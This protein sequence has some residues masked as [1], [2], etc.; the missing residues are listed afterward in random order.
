MSSSNPP[1]QSQPPAIRTFQMDDSSVGNLS[2]SVNLFRGDVNLTQSLFTLPGRSQDNGLDVTLSLLYQS[3]VFREATTW[4]REAPTGV[5]GLGWSLPLTWIEAVSSDSPVPGTRQYALYENGVPNTLVRQPWAPRLFSADAALAGGPADGKP[6]P[7][8]LV[9]EFHAHGL[10][11]SAD[12]TARGGHGTWE[13]VD[14]THELLYTLEVGER[15]LARDGGEAYQL[16]N[17]QFWKIQYYPRYE[18]WVVTNDSAVRR[19]FGGGVTRDAAG[20]RSVNETV[21]WS[22]WWKGR[23]GEPLWSGASMRTEEQVQVAR[24]WYLGR[25]TDRFGSSVT[26]AYNGFERTDGLLRGCEQRVGAGGLPYTK[27]VYLTRITDVFGR[28]VTLDYGDKLWSA[29]ETA[30]REYADPHRAVPSDAPG[31]WQDR[32]ET[33]FLDE[34]T[35]R[36]ADGSTLFT[37]RFSYDPRP[38]ASGR[39]REVANVT[40][41]T[42][43]LRGDT[44]KRFLTGITQFDQDGVASPGLVLG[45]YLDAA[46]EGGQ[47][48]ALATLT[49]PEGGTATYTYT[50]RALTRCERRAEVKRPDAVGSG[51]PR[52]YYGPDYAVV[53]YYNQANGRLSLQVWTWGGSWLT[54]Q[55]DPDDALLDT[56]GLELNSL[57]AVTN[58]DFFALTFT[59]I[60]PSERAVYVFDRDV[61]R[62]GQW[63][64][65]TIGEVTTAKNVPT[66]T[67]PT[68]GVATTFVGG[69][70]GSPW[71]G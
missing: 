25:V 17:Y 57:Q 11:L 68:T 18:R 52:V 53:T 39:E 13:L 45:Y 23:N 26:Y 4:N 37:F 43:P 29:G 3:N 28:T 7:A 41:A 33:R 40:E 46:A 70:T 50:R 42:G 2:S 63:R 59:R 56:L 61:A 65:A 1:S 24:A 55:L 19:S 60:T 64:S 48:G 30:P 5:V 22:V 54:W 69:T 31:A 14:D 12:A 71:P 20:A 66:L 6:V 58:Q 16:Q 51:S 36:A 21:A 49:S 47:P 9:E 44:F 32:Y 35:L 15:L 34:I 27:A 38:D 67:L 62:P 8:S 10:L